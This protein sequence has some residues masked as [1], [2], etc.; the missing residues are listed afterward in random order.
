MTAG[1]GAWS[2]KPGGDA[3]DDFVADGERRGGGGAGGV[4]QVERFFAFDDEEVLD[5]VAV[6]EHG[7]GADSGSAAGDVGGLDFGD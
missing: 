2:S 1:L 3:V 6:G 5:E 4:E 7:L